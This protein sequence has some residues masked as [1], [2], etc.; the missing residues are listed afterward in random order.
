MSVMQFPTTIAKIFPDKS[1]ADWILT[2]DWSV[3]NTKTWM[4]PVVYALLTLF[5][6][7]FYTQVTFKPEEMAENLN[8]SAGFVPGVRPGEAT[9]VYFER[10]LTKVSIISGLFAAVIAVTPVLIDNYTNFTGVEF[11]STSLLI[12]VGVALDFS[13]QVES[14]LV[15]RHYQGFLK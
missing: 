6:T 4:Y 14:Q 13:R 15:M 2:N 8:K 5:F 1:W 10:L 11:G 9:A 3:F 7:W 12:M